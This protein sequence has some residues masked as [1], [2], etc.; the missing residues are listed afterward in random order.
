M[1]T[2]K[3]STGE[4]L[5]S[6]G[7]VVSIG[8]SGAGIDK[9]RPEDEGVQNCGPIPMGDWSIGDAVDTATHGPVVLPLTP[10]PGTDTLGRSGFLIHGDSIKTP[11]TASH[12]CIILPRVIRESI[13][14]SSDKLL[15][16][17]SGIPTTA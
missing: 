3:Q 1:W 15:R 5:S 12:G 4:L 10:L 2:Y 8:Y 11:G 14:S 16:V 17:I 13:D 9:N 7:V 6:D